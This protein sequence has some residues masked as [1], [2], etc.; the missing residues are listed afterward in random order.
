MSMTLGLLL[1]DG[2]HPAEAPANDPAQAAPASGA[3]VQ[4]PAA[5][6]PAA[7]AIT[8]EHQEPASENHAPGQDVPHA[9]PGHAAGAVEQHAAN[10][11]AHSGDRA[12][13]GKTLEEMTMVERLE[14]GKAFFLDPTHLFHHVQDAS[15]FEVPKFMGEKW[16]LPSLVENPTEKPLVAV[17][18]FPVI[19][20]QITKFTVL[21]LAAA[22][23]LIVTFTWLARK[24]S[25]GARPM[26]KIWNLLESIVVFVRDDIARPA[27]GDHDV[28]RFL[29]FL[30][31]VFFFILALNLFGMIP[32]LG[33][34]TGSLAVTAVFAVLTFGVVVGSG[35]KKM[36]VVG[37]LK[38]QL[39]HIDLDGPMRY[40]LLPGI[41]L[42]EMFGLIV[43]HFVLAIRLFANMFAGHLVLAVF[44]GFI[45]VASATALFWG[46]AP[47]AVLASVAFSILELFVA[48]LQAYVF[49][50]LAALF[51]GAAQHA[52]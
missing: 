23:I 50:F 15:Y 36:G 17:A 40:I 31:T 12:H 1:Q 29:P 2:E 22:L 25:T 38:A 14:A 20:G 33:S 47:L 35:M 8:P 30:L 44:L 49:T 43:K 5:T 34:A 45:G 27:I 10:G 19:R 41:W 7:P 3:G 21:E 18:G 11:T 51:I 32:Y 26:G 13:S 6:E 9:E 37:F 42:I 24:A 46:V 48:V 4:E 39:P 52:H 28:K 16:H